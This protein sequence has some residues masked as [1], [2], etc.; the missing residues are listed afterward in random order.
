MSEA[1]ERTGVAVTGM[2]TAYIDATM[3]IEP[4]THA[5]RTAREGTL[6]VM[7]GQYDVAEV[8]VPRRDLRQN[9]AG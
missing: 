7:P 8:L 4:V 9:R 6:L 2:R 1:A 5:V 3:L